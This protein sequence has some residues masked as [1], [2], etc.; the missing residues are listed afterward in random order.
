MKLKLQAEWVVLNDEL[1][2]FT[3]CFLPCDAMLA[4][5]M[6]ASCIRPR[7]SQHGTV[8]KWLNVGSRKQHHMMAQ[9][10]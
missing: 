10:V 9:G 6:L 2:V 5:Y 4:Q 8:P 3:N 7:L 1:F